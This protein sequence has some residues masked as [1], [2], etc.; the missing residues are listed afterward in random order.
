MDSLIEI[1]IKLII[2]TDNNTN[3]TA[4][5]HYYR[6]GSTEISEKYNYSDAIRMDFSKIVFLRV[7]TGTDSDLDV[8]IFHC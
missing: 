5:N 2:I 3:T 6:T 8:Y 1:V 4:Y 7:E